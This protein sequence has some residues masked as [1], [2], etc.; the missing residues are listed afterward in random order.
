MWVYLDYDMNTIDDMQNEMDYAHHYNEFRYNQD[1]LKDSWK[2]D[3]VMEE[4][5][6]W[7][8]NVYLYKI[9]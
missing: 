8:G 3:N 4:H 7:V 5:L 2:I 9:D 6:K 1:F